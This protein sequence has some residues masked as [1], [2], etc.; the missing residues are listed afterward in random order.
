MSAEPER[1][2]GQ[3]ANTT[4]ASAQT[5]K[6][7]VLWGRGDEAEVV[8]FDGER[9]LVVSPL[10]AAPGTPLK[11]RLAA[12][13]IAIE[14]KV[15]SCKRSPDGRFAVAGRVVSLTRELRAALS[16]LLSPEGEPPPR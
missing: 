2:D 16:G 12:P 7:R 8:S 4:P 14:L 1:P 9:M 3:P 5:N 15:S 11:G 13:D 10:P 6:A